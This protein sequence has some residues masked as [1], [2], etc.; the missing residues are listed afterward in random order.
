MAGHLDR[1]FLVVLL[2]TSLVLNP[3]EL[4]INNPTYGSAPN[5]AQH[6]L[7]LM[8]TAVGANDNVLA[9]F[10]LV[11]QDLILSFSPTKN[12]QAFA[13]ILVMQPEGSLRGGASIAG[14]AF[15]NTKKLT[16]STRRE[17][18]KIV[19]ISIIGRLRLNKWKV[20]LPKRPIMTRKR[21]LALNL[22]IFYPRAGSAAFS[23]AF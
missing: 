2:S 6:W 23:G 10:S 8:I 5:K 14:Q 13:R 11:K 7:N 4:I 15:E 9:A 21:L 3:L 16:I 18:E 20:S 19:F 22:L 1:G 12:L 17:R